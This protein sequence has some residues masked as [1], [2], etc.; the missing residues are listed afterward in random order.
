MRRLPSS[1]TPTDTMPATAFVMN[2]SVASCRCCTVSLASPRTQVET[3]RLLEHPAPHHP[4]D[5]AAIEGGRGQG[6][7]PKHEKIRHG[8]ANQVTVDI[9]HETLPNSLVAPFGARQHRIEPVQRLEAGQRRIRSYRRRAH[10]QALGNLRDGGRRGRGQRHHPRAALPA[11]GAI[12]PG[13]RPAGHDE[14]EHRVGVRF[15]PQCSSRRNDCGRGA[16][17]DSRRHPSYNRSR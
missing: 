13:A 15:R 9:A 6:R 8:A 4:G 12:S 11:A 16:G 3:R 14:L 5:A 7:A 10:P 2:T 17:I 1:M